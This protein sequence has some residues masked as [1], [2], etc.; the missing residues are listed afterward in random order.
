VRSAAA[1]SQTRH[2]EAGLV[3]RVHGRASRA[4]N[5]AAQVST[6]LVDGRHAEA[7]AQGGAHPSSPPNAGRSAASRLVGEAVT[8]SARRSSR[9]ALRQARWPSPRFSAA[10][11]SPSSAIW[12]TNQGS[13]CRTL[14]GH[15]V[16]R[17]WPERS[18][19][20]RPRSTRSVLTVAS[21]AWN[22][23]GR[24]VAGDGNVGR[25]P[26]PGRSPASA[27]PCCKRLR[28]GAAERHGLADGLHGGRQRRRSAPG[29]FSKAKRGILTA[30]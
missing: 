4:A 3:G 2:A 7:A 30:T 28:E 9:R 13:N 17:D 1:I 12:S 23:L 8:P 15:V 6:R 14:L 18:A 29:N 26:G 11:I 19:C 27:A 16:D 24:P 5:S 10:T 22:C 25:E 20:A 21:A